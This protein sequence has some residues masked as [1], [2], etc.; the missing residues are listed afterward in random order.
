MIRNESGERLKEIVFGKT[1]YIHKT[2]TEYDYLIDKSN[3][4]VKVNLTFTKNKEKNEKAKEG[5]RKFFSGI[6]S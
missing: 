5:L 2:D 6:S 3:N 1:K 4:K